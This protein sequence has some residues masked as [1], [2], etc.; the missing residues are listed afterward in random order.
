MEDQYQAEA[1]EGLMSKLTLQQPSADLDMI[2]GSR[3]CEPSIA[4]HYLGCQRFV[5]EARV[6]EE[7]KMPDQ[8]ND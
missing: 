8:C 3:R 1:D 7:R 2:F 4:G 5:C 6:A